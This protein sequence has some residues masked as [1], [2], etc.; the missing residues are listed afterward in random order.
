MYDFRTPA[1]LLHCLQHTAG[2]ENGTF[3]I[4]GIFVSFL[5]SYHLAVKEIVIVVDEVHLHACRL[6]GS[7]FDN[8]RMIGVIDDQIHA[9]K[10][11][12]FV[13]LVSSLIDISPLGHKGANLTAFFLNVLWKFSAHDGQR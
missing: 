2:I 11:D 9:R 8:Q 7:D 13:K 10:A 6:D 4:V 1:K 3:V 12:N 5:I